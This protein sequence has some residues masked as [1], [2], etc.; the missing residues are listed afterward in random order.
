MNIDYWIQNSFNQSKRVRLS[1]L[2]QRYEFLS[3]HLFNE[4]EPTRKAASMRTREFMR[5]LESWLDQFPTIDEK[6]AVFVSI[7]YLFFAGSKEFDELYRCAYVRSQR[8]VLQIAGLNPF[9]EMDKLKEEMKSVWFCPITD[10]FRINGY[11]HVV[12]ISGH[13]YRPDW[14]SLC[15]L[16]DLS[17]AKRFISDQN[18]RYLVLLEDFSGSGN[19]IKN[20]VGQIASKIKIPILIIPL[21][22]CKPAVELINQSIRQTNSIS[23]D[24]IVELPEI[25]LLGKTNNLEN[26]KHF[27]D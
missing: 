16:S 25:V 14:H 1:E 17:R 8:W 7:E 27:Q 4:Y 13:S 22:I 24:P 6:E 19:Q 20:V 5:R 23:L 12:G 11:L 26:Q 10:S 3:T 2:R 15:K 21:I 18:I 9:A